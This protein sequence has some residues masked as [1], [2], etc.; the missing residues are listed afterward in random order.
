MCLPPS[1]L[2]GY[3]ELKDCE[4][5]GLYADLWVYSFNIT[6]ELRHLEDGPS[7]ICLAALGPPAIHGSV[8]QN[9]KAAGIVSLVDCKPGD[10]SQVWSVSK[11]VGTVRF[12]EGMCLK[13][14]GPP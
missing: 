9:N 7:N 2:P 3:L 13:Y 8:R 10:S 12:G 11:G 14:G 1:S 6:G 5:G 4:S